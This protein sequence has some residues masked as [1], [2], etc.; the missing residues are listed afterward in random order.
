MSSDIVIDAANLGKAYAIFKH[1]KDRLKQMLVGGRKKYYSEYWALRDVTLQI[2][3]GETVA[4]IGHNGSGKSTFLQLVSQ[5]LTPTTGRVEVRGRVGALLELGA[6]FNPEFSGRE[7]VHLAA[8]V[9]GLSSDEIAA[10]FDLIEEFAGIGDFLDQP[11]KTYSSGMY[12]R[13]AFAVMAHVAPDILIVDEILAVG[14]AAFQQKCLRFIKRFK[15][16]GTLLFVSHDVA[17]VLALCDKAVWLDAGSVRA[18]GSAKEVCEAYMV[19]IEGEKTNTNAFKIGGS[20]QSA[21]EPVEMQDVRAVQMKELGLTPKIEVFAFDPDAPWH[22]QRG[23]TIENVRILNAEG[24]AISAFEGGEDIT[25]QIEAVAH[26]DIEQPIV[27]FVVKNRLG[28]NIF[29]DNTYLSYVNHPLQVPVGARITA[30][31]EFR[32]PL[33]P[34]GHYAVSIAIAEGRQGE[35]VQHQWLDEALLF[36]VVAPNLTSGLVGIPMKSISLNMVERA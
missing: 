36:D 19:A 34:A 35:H 13:L 25:L 26:Q 16:N 14:D 30:A 21:R 5:T 7:N 17:A 12:A 11:V 4:L 22:G 2:A 27:G 29:G 20:R 8:S 9:L 28:Q 33:L 31:F 23:A 15:E 24:E 1:P 32:V 18:I 6:G 10:R 3:R